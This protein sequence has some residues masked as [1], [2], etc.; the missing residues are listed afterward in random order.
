M[1][2]SKTS[3]CGIIKNVTNAIASLQPQ[4]IYECMP[5]ND[6][7]LQQTKLK[8]YQIARFPH[9]IGAVDCTHVRLQSPGG[10]DA[11]L[12]RNRKEYFSWNVQV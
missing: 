9:V 3:A 10:N 7:E 1:G 2:V 4:F 12:Y 11:E 8:F 6:E 5:R